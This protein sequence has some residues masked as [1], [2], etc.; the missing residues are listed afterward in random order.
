MVV[1]VSDGAYVFS[2]GGPDRTVNMWKVNTAALDAAE[3]VGGGGLA[4]Y[5]KLLEGG[6][7]GPLHQ[8]VRGL[9]G[10]QMKKMGG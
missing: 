5:L 10:K 8:E 3:A 2:S 7:E 4:P 9:G 1:W 6:A